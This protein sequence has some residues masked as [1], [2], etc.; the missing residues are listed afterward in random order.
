MRKF[1]VPISPT[2]QPSHKSGR[3]KSIHTFKNHFVDGLT[4]VD[5]DF[6]VREE[7]RLIS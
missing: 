4:P 7:D 2:V 1:E 3:E 5:P 6:P